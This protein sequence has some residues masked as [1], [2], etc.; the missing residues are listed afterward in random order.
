MTNVLDI[1]LDLFVDPR[2]D[3]FSTKPGARAANVA[4]W[5]PA[6]V[7][8][9]MTSA[10]GLSLKRKLPG[11]AF[12]THEQILYELSQI[13]PPVR[14]FH[15][16]AHADLGICINCSRFHAEFLAID[17][18]LRASLL[19]DFEPK[20]GDWL[21][22]AIACGFVDELDYVMHPEMYACLRRNR[23]H[24]I[25]MGMDKWDDE[26]TDDYLYL[27]RFCGPRQQY[28]RRAGKHTLDRRIPLRIHS[29][30]DFW[31]PVATFDFMFITRSP[32][33]TP[34]TSDLSYA[35]LQEEFLSK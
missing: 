1:D 16:D 27:K 9:Y 18:D 6:M 14:L 21:L 17:P 31:S 24:D 32:R 30:D 28:E 3:G 5:D 7:R 34:V 15:L 23:L 12:E 33:F 10:L 19:S 8:E 11:R 20:E 4:A 29:R 25:P 2:T 13:R 22:Y 35:I 26:C